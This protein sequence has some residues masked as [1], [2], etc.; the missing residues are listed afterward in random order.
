MRS[1]KSNNHACWT[2]DIEGENPL[3]LWSDAEDGGTPWEGRVNGRFDCLNEGFPKGRGDGKFW[4]A[5]ERGR[6]SSLRLR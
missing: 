4:R 6:S 2:Q 1:H 5:L 3:L